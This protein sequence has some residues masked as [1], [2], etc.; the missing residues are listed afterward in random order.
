MNKAMPRFIAMFLSVV[1]L[2]PMLTSVGSTPTYA[3]PSTGEDWE[4]VKTIL[5][6]AG[7]SWEEPDFADAVSNTMPGT[8][9][10]GNGDV[11]VVSA[12]STEEKTYLISK[13]DFWS[14]GWLDTKDTS[15]TANRKLSIL[16]LGGITIKPSQEQKAGSQSLTREE[17]V[18]IKASSHLNSSKPDFNYLPEYM[19]DGVIGKQGDGNVPGE[20]WCSEWEKNDPD[21]SIE[22]DLGQAKTISKYI[23]YHAQSVFAAK[24]QWN[25]REYTVEY[26]IDGSKWEELDH[27]KDNT[28]AMTEK[29]FD[30]VQARYIRVKILTAASDLSETRARIAEIELFED[31]DADS[32]FYPQEE[33]LGLAEGVEVTASSH[34][35]SSK[36]DYNYLPK[37]IVD[38]TIGKST[39]PGEGWVSADQAT[40]PA[41]WIQVDLKENKKISKYV[42]YHTESI[43]PDRANRNTKEYIIEASVDGEEWITLDHVTDNTAAVTQCVFPSTEARYVRVRIKQA[44]QSVSETRANIVELELFRYPGTQS[45]L[46]ENQTVQKHESK[47]LSE[48]QDIAGAEVTTEMSIDQVPVTL[49]TW[50]SATENVLVTEITSNGAKDVELDAEVW[51]KQGSTDYTQKSDISQEGK[52]VWAS[53]NTG[54]KVPKEE[55]SWA[56]EAAIFT[57]L[58]GEDPGQ[59]A[60]KADNKSALSFT[61]KAGE[62]RYLL[63]T[64]GGGGQTYNNKGELNGAVPLDEAIGLSGNYQSGEDIG[65]LQEQH[66]QW[67]KDYWMKSYINIGDDDYHR[68]YYGSQYY[69]GCTARADK[70][71]PG[72]YGIF[73]TTDSPSWCGDYHLNY[74]YYAPFY[75][76]YSSNRY[77]SVV[78]L[79]EP[80]F[81]YMEQG[82]IN[83]KNKLET[84]FGDY[85]KNR[86]DLADGIDNGLLYPCG[87]GPWGTT[88][89]N[90]YMTQTLNAPFAATMII[91]YYNYSMDQEFLTQKAY[92]FLEKIADFYTQWCEKEDLGDGNYRYNLYDGPH[93]DWF[94]KNSGVT[95]GVVQNVYET[96][97]NN[98]DILRAGRDDVTEEKLNIWK[99]MY[100]HMA[101]VP[102]REYSAGNFNGKIFSLTEEGTD[103]NRAGSASVELE[104]VHPGE[105]LSFDSDPELLQIGRDTVKAK[106]AANASIWGQINNT[107]KMFTQAIRLG[108]DPAY[109]M[110]KFRSS[111]L[112]K[113]KANFTI[114]DGAHGIEKAGAIEFINN[115]L[116][117]SSNGFIKVFP[118]WTGADAKFHTLRE[119]GAYLVSSSMSG[120]EVEY[121]D[122]ISETGNPVQLVCPWEEVTV[123]DD[124][125]SDVEVTYERT[126]NTDEKVAVFQTEAGKT[127]HVEKGIPQ[128]QPDKTKLKELYDEA[129]QKIESDYTGQSWKEFSEALEEAKGYWAMNRHCRK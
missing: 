93:E 117:Q 50:M 106:E 59:M 31:P 92:P 104:F 2:V 38:G 29:R 111:N 96:L 8:A 88:A 103:A 7:G 71:A 33:S 20:G 95:I 62:T 58:L 81:D 99:D 35:K 60:R 54:N 23:I 86:E 112:A 40:D 107:S 55:K 1:L 53:R 30:P 49:N 27:V 129:V 63:T 57:R 108:C 9:L 56:S 47:V 11:G 10:M 84:V 82:E 80:I 19:I 122:I 121:V 5:D 126:L 118:N 15:I 68:Y 69:M 114:N 75:G 39:V 37:Y 65:R 51:T 36:P 127:Y 100:E 124:Q 102:I 85:V 73:I 98:Y 119:K 3:A 43:F 52:G 41:C 61:L 120:G 42:M 76:M 97:I 113:M 101:D 6:K 66:R 26:S 110:D 14:S 94:G 123:T 13:G 90:K 34:L 12:G 91:S 28:E 18:A 109:I 44:S 72:L 79:T 24:P 46:Q 64:V 67:W 116:L 125:N 25:T 87:L 16:T 89:I 21:R 22:I 74:N 32:E 78:A 77:E 105:R 115:M 48:S 17:G 4:E 83:A 128:E 45:K 70:T